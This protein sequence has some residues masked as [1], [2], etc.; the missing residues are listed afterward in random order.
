[1]VSGAFGHRIRGPEVSHLARSL[2]PPKTCVSALSLSAHVYVTIQLLIHARVDEGSRIPPRRN[3]AELLKLCWGKAA[4]VP[5][6][7]VIVVHRPL[8]VT[9]TEH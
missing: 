5:T 1:M 3:P 8:P 6:P 7:D 2:T 4:M 9:A